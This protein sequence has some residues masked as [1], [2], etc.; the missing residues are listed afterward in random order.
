MPLQAGLASASA[1]GVAADGIRCAVSGDGSKV[2]FTAQSDA[3]VS[4]DNNGAVDLFLKDLNG[5]G[6]Q[7]LVAAAVLGQVFCLGMTPNAQTVVYTHSSPSIL[8][9]IFI[10]NLLTGSVSRVTPAP[11]SLLNVA[12]YQFAGISDDGL[13]LALIA[14]PTSTSSGDDTT[15]LGPAHL[16]LRDLGTSQWINLDAQVRFTTEQGRARGNAQIAPDGRGLAVTSCAPH[17][18]AGDHNAKCG[19]FSHHLDTGPPGGRHA[20]AHAAHRPVAWPPDRRPALAGGLCVAGDHP[21]LQPG[22]HA[23]LPE[24]QQRGGA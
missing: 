18:E 24:R 20:L 17:P 6:V 7:R 8:P 16:L 9:P 4:G 10:K 19:V 13:R 21:A 15:A 1:S 5:N 23:V 2:L 14:Q 3:L 12:G 11:G 22:L